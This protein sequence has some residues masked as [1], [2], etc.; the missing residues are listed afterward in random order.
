MQ[1]ILTKY[2][3]ATNTRGSRI[4]AMCDR[5]A[6][7]ISYPHELNGD[8][9]H[10]AAARALVARFV[11]ED[12]ARYG[13]ERNPWSKP[14]VCGQLPNGDYAHVCADPQNQ[15]V[16]QFE[17]HDDLTAFK[18]YHASA[19]ETDGTVTGLKCGI[20]CAALKRSKI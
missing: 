4:K 18:N 11:K 12:A 14:R 2:L 17:N 3:P 5:G 20:M 15:A 8:A 10:I 13:T 9:C 7:T 6:I 19:V 1:A 16:I